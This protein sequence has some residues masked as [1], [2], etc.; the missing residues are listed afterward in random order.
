MKKIFAIIALFVISG[1][2]FAQSQFV[3]NWEGS[4]DVGKGILLK[5]IFHIT[6][7]G[8]T[9]SATMDSPNQGVMGIACQHLEA[10]GDSIIID[11]SNVGVVYNGKLD[12]QAIR[13]KWFQAGRSTSID[14]FKTEKTTGLA[15]PQTPE[16]PFD[17][18]VEDVIYH[19]K[20]KSIQYGATITMPKGNGPFPTVMLITG[21][22][23]QNRDEEL[24]GHKP[25][26]VIADYLTKRGYLVIR[27]DDRGVGK[28]TGDVLNATTADFANDVMQGVNYLETR[29]EVNTKKIVLMGHSEGGII[30]PMVASKRKDIYAIV[31]LAGPGIKITQLMEEQSAAIL[32]GSS[33]DSNMVQ[34]Y[35]VL[36][37]DM[38]TAVLSATDSNDAKNRI[39]LVMDRWTKLTSPQIVSALGLENSENK[40]AYVRSFVDIYNNKWFNYFLRMDPTPVLESLTCKVLALNGEKDVQVIAKSNLNGIREALSKSK[41][42]GFD[43]GEVPGLNHLF[44]QC[45]TCTSGEYGAIT[46][47]ISPVVLTAIGDWLD[48]RVR[49]GK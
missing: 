16:P 1:T 12:G 4:V 43:V 48:T 46:Q 9:L 33:P 32:E 15:R 45:N 3:G 22:G 21:S 42:A 13:G 31:L 10:L 44:Q 49:D 37:H 17:Y 14:F 41:S 30:A 2:G 23:Q 34:R 39:N 18:K 8:D 19:N 24:F 40:D 6:Q 25:F 26:A 27:V 7:S 5:L 20:D 47:T 28:T 35:K 36:Y 29:K 11:M 38:E